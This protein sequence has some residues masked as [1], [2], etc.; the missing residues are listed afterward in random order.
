[1]QSS[2]WIRHRIHDV[3]TEGILLYIATLFSHGRK[4]AKGLVL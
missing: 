3:E 2:S 4:E 1:M